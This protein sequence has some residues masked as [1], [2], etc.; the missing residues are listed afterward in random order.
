MEVR[1]HLLGGTH[2]SRVLSPC[3]IVSA[4]SSPPPTYTHLLLLRVCCPR[5]TRHLDRKGRS[6]STCVSQLG[7]LPGRGRP[8]LI[9]QLCSSVPGSPPVAIERQRERETSISLKCI[10]LRLGRRRALLWVWPCVF[11]SSLPPRHQDFHSLATYLSQSTSS[12]FL[13]TISD[14]HLLLFLVTNEVMP[15]QVR[16]S[17]RLRSTHLAS[18][19]PRWGLCKEVFPFLTCQRLGSSPLLCPVVCSF[20]QGLIDR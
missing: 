12:V 3:C 1:S 7:H 4:L 6:L 15:L 5:S 13:D 16:V 2:E 19:V 11:I 10:Q 17:V 18:V 20:S 14:F 9:A 8:Q